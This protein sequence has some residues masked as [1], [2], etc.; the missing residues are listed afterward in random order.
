MLVEIEIGDGDRVAAAVGLAGK[1]GSDEKLP[2]SAGGTERKQGN[3]W[4]K[5]RNKKR[6]GRKWPL[7]AMVIILPRRHQDESEGDE[8]EYLLF[9]LRHDASRAGLPE[10]DCSLRALSSHK[11]VEA[12]LLW[13]KVIRVIHNKILGFPQIVSAYVRKHIFFGGLTCT[14]LEH[15]ILPRIRHKMR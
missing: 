13:G 7:D 15:Q 10:R 2:L 1:D 6:K 5:N 9:F 12:G 8:E 3:G 11:L 14:L 4:R